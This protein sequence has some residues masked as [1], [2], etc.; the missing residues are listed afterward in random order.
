MSTFLFSNNSVGCK[1]ISASFNMPHLRKYCH[2]LI[3]YNFLHRT[4]LS[5]HVFLRDTVHVCQMSF[6][7]TE[8]YTLLMAAS[9]WYS[10]TPLSM[11]PDIRY[12]IDCTDTHIHT[13]KVWL[14]WSTVETSVRQAGTKGYTARS[15][16]RFQ[17]N[18]NYTSTNQLHGKA[19]SHTEFLYPAITSP[20][21]IPKFSDQYAFRPTG[22]PMAAI[23]SPFNKCWMVTHLLIDNRYIIVISLDYSKAFDTVR[24]S[25]LLDKMAQLDVP[26]KVNHWLISFF[27]VHSHCTRYRGEVSTVSEVSK[28]S[29]CRFI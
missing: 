26:D 3:Y 1:L 16:C 12:A 6:T 25:A 29:K 7:H 24:H 14:V 18:I 21:T 23:I 9:T 4:A 15:P 20:S 22:S 19:D 28:V 10:I 8:P 27:S 11:L 13:W 17:S 2:F 5:T